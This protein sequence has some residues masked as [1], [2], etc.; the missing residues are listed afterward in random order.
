MISNMVWPEYSPQVKF[1]VTNGGLLPIEFKHWSK[2]S[3]EQLSAI[4]VTSLVVNTLSLKI[5]ENESESVNTKLM[6]R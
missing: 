2:L 6:S 4:T 1:R 3:G 5:V